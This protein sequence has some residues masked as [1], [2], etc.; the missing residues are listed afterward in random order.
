MCFAKTGRAFL[1]ATVVFVA[2]GCAGSGFGLSNAVPPSPPPTATQ[3]RPTNLFPAAAGSDNRPR[4]RTVP[5][6]IRFSIV[7]SDVPLGEVSESGKIWNHVDED[8]LK[9][10]WAAHLRRNGIRVGR[11]TSSSWPPIRA[12]LESARGQRSKH[13]VFDIRT[14]DSLTLEID[15]RPRD[16]SL[17]LYRPDGSMAG[18]TFMQSTNVLR[19]D[20]TVRPTELDTVALRIVPEVRQPNPDGSWAFTPEGL[21]PALP[22]ISRTLHE[23]AVETEVPPDHFIMIGPS[24]RADSPLLIGQALL[25]DTVDGQPFESV[26][27]ITPEVRR[28]TGAGA[29]P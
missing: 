19:I 6:L 25:T 28:T 18:A 20:F 22:Y 17:F 16:R 12:I 3:P 11:G 29:P 15:T 13:E 5:V 21:R 23:L 7:R 10:D 14:G 1:G 4:P 2:G 26:Y 8:I 9:A 27:F 24:G